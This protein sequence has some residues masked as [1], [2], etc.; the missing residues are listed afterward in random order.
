MEKLLIYSF[1]AYGLTNILVHGKIFD[2]PRH[3]IINKSSFFKGLLTCMMCLSTWVGMLLSF[4][5]F[6]PV[7]S[8]KLVNPIL[9]WHYGM[10]YPVIIFL[11]AMFTSGIVWV[12]HNIEEFFERGF[13]KD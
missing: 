1:I 6:S 13:K 11:D 2:K 10:F 8:L 4:T 3:W 12:I 7:M 9:D 5:L